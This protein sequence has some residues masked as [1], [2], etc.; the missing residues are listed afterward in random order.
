MST[1]KSGSKKIF[2]LKG[3]CQNNGYKGVTRECILSAI[4]SENEKVKGW[5]KEALVR[6]TAMQESESEHNNN[7]K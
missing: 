7:V 4:G 6:N 1:V 5:A 3:W 2:S